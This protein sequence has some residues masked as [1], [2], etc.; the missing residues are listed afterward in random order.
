MLGNH[1]DFGRTLARLQVGETRLGATQPF[2]GLAPRRRFVLALERKQ[3]RA[4]FHRIAAPHRDLL[5]SARERRGDAQ[6]FTFDVA[7]QRSLAGLP[8]RDERERGDPRR[9]QRRARPGPP[10]ARNLLHS[11]IKLT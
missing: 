8:A 6:V 9:N 5:Q 10:F 4:G 11:I 7:R 2:L 1:L 3:G